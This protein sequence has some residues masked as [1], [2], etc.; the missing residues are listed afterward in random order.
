MGEARAGHRTRPRGVGNELTPSL[1]LPL[2]GEVNCQRGALAIGWGQFRASPLKLA[3]LPHKG[4]GKKR[5]PAAPVHEAPRLHI[6]EK[7]LRQPAGL[8]HLDL[9]RHLERD[10]YR[11]R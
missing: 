3:S 5:L 10:L 11:V 6:G 9:R 8:Q 2:K 1:D 7:K 4:E